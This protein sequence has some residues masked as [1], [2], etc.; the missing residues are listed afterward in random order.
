MCLWARTDPQG[1]VLLKYI[2]LFHYTLL[3]QL[4]PKVVY[5]FVLVTSC[6]FQKLQPVYQCLHTV[7]TCD[8]CGW[9]VIHA[10]QTFLWC[11]HVKY[12]YQR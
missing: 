4:F 12:N 3:K 2:R 11:L 7:S 8:T 1:V 6:L 5:L 9:M 10:G